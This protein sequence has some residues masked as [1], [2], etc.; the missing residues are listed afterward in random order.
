MSE[1]LGGSMN[2]ITLFLIA[3]SLSMDAFSVAIC[4]G[5]GLREVKLDKALLVGLYFGAFQGIMPVLG[6]FVGSSFA[7][8]IQAWDH[9][10][11][12]ILLAIL[13]LNMIWEADSQKDLSGG[14]SFKEMLPLAIAT[15]IDA[16][17]IGVSLAVL[18][19]NIYQSASFIGLCT[20]LLSFVGF[21]LGHYFGQKWEK[22]AQVLGGILLIL[23]GSKVLLEHL[24]Y[25]P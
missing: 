15:S 18:K 25:L 4:K 13:G 5:L 14:F 20:F 11:A 3:V 24:G 7:K 19:V 6:Y 8:T 22:W 9:W 16:L 21:Y 12:F 10:I 1:N 17:I 2:H 23:I